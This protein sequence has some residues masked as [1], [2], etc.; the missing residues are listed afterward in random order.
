LACLAIPSLE[1]TW[2]Q[3]LRQSVAIAVSPDG[4][5]MAWAGG[6]HAGLLETATGREI[7]SFRQ[8]CEIIARIAFAGPQHLMLSSYD[9]TLVF[10]SLASAAVTL[11]SRRQPACAELLCSSDLGRWL[12]IDLQ[13]QLNWFPPP[14]R[15]L[16]P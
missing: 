12:S 13:N 8:P 14:S 16:P 4:A 11:E 15:N 7:S 9:Q 2:Q 3:S 1:L 5:T 10:A 6:F